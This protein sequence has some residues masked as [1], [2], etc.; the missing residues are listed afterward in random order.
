ME[1]AR[2]FEQLGTVFNMTQ[3]QMALRTGKERA[4]IS[5]IVRLLRL[6]MTIQA[7]VETGKLTAGH[8]KV[9]LK[10]EKDGN[11]AMIDAGLKIV[12]MELSVRQ[13]EG[14]V[15]DLLAGR[16][17]MKEKPAAKERVMD[18]NVRA[19]E[20][21]LREKLGL[22]V[23]IDDKGGTGRVVIGYAGVEEFDRILEALGE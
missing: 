19:A 8:A 21:R 10:L 17:G 6:P 16:M 15:D 7:Y 3:E 2:A 23:Q 5:N 18:P 13:A 12:G 20:Q 14:F 9:V 22:R 4:S 11:D 1:E